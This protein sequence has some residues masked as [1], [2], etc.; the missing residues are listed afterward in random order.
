MH[1]EKP[2]KKL[3]VNTG[4]VNKELL[5]MS[6]AISALILYA[7]LVERSNHLQIN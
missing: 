6:K 3:N 4:A 7:L 5:S 1:G 2:P